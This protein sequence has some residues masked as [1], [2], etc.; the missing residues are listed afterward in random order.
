MSLIQLHERYHLP[1]FIVENAI[2]IKEEMI[3]GK[4][5]DDNRIDYYQEHIQAMKTAIE[6]DGVDVIGY[7]A[8]SKY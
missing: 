4:I 5:Y 1:I 8:W 3:N 7:L 6:N 2:G